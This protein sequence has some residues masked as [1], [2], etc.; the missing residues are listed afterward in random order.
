MLDETEVETIPDA[1]R[2][3]EPDPA[4]ARFAELRNTVG[5]LC[6]AL[7]GAGDEIKWTPKKLT[8]YINDLFSVE[9][10]INSLSVDDMFFLIGDLE[11]RLVDLERTEPAEEEPAQ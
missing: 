2:V 6:Q 7:N 5:E 10:G 9:N 11:A 1:V 3:S 8:E 4:E